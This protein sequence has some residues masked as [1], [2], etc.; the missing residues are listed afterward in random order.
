MAGGL[1]FGAASLLDEAA[2]SALAG[3]ASA[4]EAVEGGGGVGVENDRRGMTVGL[5]RTCAAR[6]EMYDMI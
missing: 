5:R 4:V 1:N 6:R 2:A 3:L